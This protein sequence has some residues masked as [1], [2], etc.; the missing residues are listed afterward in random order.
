[1][2][3]KRFY[4]FSLWY[5]Q[6]Y[7]ITA[8]GKIMVHVNLFR[9]FL[10]MDNF[11]SLYKADSAGGRKMSRG[12]ECSG[13]LAAGFWQAIP[14]Y[15]KTV[16][17]RLLFHQIN[18]NH[19]THT[20]LAEQNCIYS[21]KLTSVRLWVSIH[22]DSSPKFQSF[23]INCGITSSH[24]CHVQSLLVLKEGSGLESTFQITATFS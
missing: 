12:R 6:H 19:Q 17:Q 15:W 14:E 16:F 7:R 23:D 9:E 4:Q 18:L 24:T 3:G 13:Y 2:Q 1:M 10:E 21:A 11:F 5:P 8:P 22:C 20:E